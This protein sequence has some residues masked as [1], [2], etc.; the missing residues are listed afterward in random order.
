MHWAL[1]LAPFFI[2]SVIQYTGFCYDFCDE[3]PLAVELIVA[4]K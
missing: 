2:V 1:K 4:I 3:C